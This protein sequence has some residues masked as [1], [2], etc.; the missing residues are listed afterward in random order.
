MDF[1]DYIEKM[2]VWQ[3]FLVLNLIVISVAV[4]PYLV[5]DLAKSASFA[6]FWKV[7]PVTFAIG[8]AKAL[9]VIFFYE[10]YPVFFHRAF[11]I[12]IVALLI[13]AIYWAVISIFLSKFLEI[14]I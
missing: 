11:H 12:V 3:R 7:A 14:I 1:F 6:F 13:F 10:K 5:I 8:E 4:V 9:I 2:K